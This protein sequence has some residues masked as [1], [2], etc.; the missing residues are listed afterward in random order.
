MNLLQVSIRTSENP[1]PIPTEPSKSMESTRA[2]EIIFDP[3]LESTTVDEN[4]TTPNVADPTIQTLSDSTSLLPN[5]Q[6]ELKE[7][8]RRKKA[9]LD[10]SSIITSGKRQ[11]TNKKY[12]K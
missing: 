4:V 1:I 9:H 11:R 5:S 7:R 3:V 10:E 12:S 8:K 2:S 6:P